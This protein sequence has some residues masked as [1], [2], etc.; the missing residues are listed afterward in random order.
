MS[1]GWS[2]AFDLDNG[3]IEDSYEFNIWY[4]SELSKSKS[5][6]IG[7][8]KL[9]DIVNKYSV[10]FEYAVRDYWSILVE[11]RIKDALEEL[12]KIDD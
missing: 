7:D 2:T 8:K 10:D 3:G 12:N 6:N 9:V 5:K 11:E 4:N 1:G